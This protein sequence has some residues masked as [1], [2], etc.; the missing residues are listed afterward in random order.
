MEVRLFRD[1][2]AGG[3]RRVNATKVHRKSGG[4][5]SFDSS[6]RRGAIFAQLDA[7][8]ERAAR[9]HT[10]EGIGYTLLSGH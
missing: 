5:L 4:W 3:S 1:A 7:P 8:G 10:R 6:E 9:E 2:E